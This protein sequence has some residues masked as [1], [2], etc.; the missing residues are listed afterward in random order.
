MLSLPS[1]RFPTLHL[2][3]LRTKMLLQD[4]LTEASV[5]GVLLV[6]LGKVD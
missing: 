1:Q 6:I 4:R 2:L 3:R 5:D